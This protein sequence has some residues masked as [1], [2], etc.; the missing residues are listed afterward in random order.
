MNKQ[1]II[2]KIFIL[3]MIIFTS[4]TMAA[5]DEFK[6]YISKPCSQYTAGINGIGRAL[7]T[8]QK[9]GY[10]NL[11]G[12]S[13]YRV[14][15]SADEVLEYIAGTGKNY[16]L[17]V[18]SHG[19]Q[20]AFN[21]RENQWITSNDVS[22]YWHLVALNSCLSMTDDS[23]ARA[24]HTVGYS[25]RAS[26]GWYKTVTNEAVAEWWGY[27]YDFAGTTNLRDAALKAAD[28]CTNN[29]PI[30]LYGDKTNWTGVAW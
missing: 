11:L 28:K 13:C 23:F 2:I 19:D 4:N 8:F 16:G 5:T 29:T 6:A 27:F 20:G 1:R 18:L 21:M 12:D 22:G 15:D 30:R 17:I 3:I 24:F 26:I 25:N 7:L 10:I 14:T 9:L